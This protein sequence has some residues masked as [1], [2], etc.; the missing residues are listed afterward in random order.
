[1]IL[2]K[3]ALFFKNLLQ[4]I[5]LD[6]QGHSQTVLLIGFYEITQENLPMEGKQEYK[7]MFS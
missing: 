5:T 1:M 3:K 7:K 4:F 2:E 6:L